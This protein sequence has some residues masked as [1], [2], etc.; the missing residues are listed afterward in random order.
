MPLPSSACTLTTLCA[1]WTPSPLFLVV[2]FADFIKSFAPRIPQK[3]C[4]RKMRLANEKS[5][6]I[7]QR[8]Q[9]ILRPAPVVTV[10]R[11]LNHHQ[12]R[13]RLH[14]L[15]DLVSFYGLRRFAPH[16]LFK[17]KKRTFSLWTYKLHT[18]GDYV[19]TIRALGTTDSYSTQTVRLEK[20]LNVENI[21]SD[22][23]VSSNIGE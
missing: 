3:I 6:E 13:R 4:R 7:R 16:N 11:L 14:D 18:L 10:P 21:L 15:L 20:S 12:H 8:Q 22:Q 23:R 9:Q 17:G 2:N 5:S 19:R 1:S